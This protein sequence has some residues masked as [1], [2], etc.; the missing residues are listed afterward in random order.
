MRI[1]MF[2]QQASYHFPVSFAVARHPVI[3]YFL[4]QHSYGL[5]YRRQTT[6]NILESGQNWEER[7]HLILEVLLAV[8]ALGVDHLA[9][10]FIEVV[11]RL[12]RVERVVQ[13][14]GDELD[15]GI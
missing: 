4:R 3:F 12:I 5:G 15:E 8:T 7:D 9:H 13:P 6:L 10:V 2:T 14:S 11:W 1:R